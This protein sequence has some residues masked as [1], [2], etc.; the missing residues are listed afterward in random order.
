MRTKSGE[1]MLPVWQVFD[2]HERLLVAASTRNKAH[3]LIDR[4]WITKEKLTR[5]KDVY[6]A[7]K[8]RRL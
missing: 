4:G 6:A 3:S 5:I 1:V 7:G 2:E 8:A